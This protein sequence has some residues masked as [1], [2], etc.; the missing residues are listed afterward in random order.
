MTE[1]QLIDFGFERNDETIESSGAPYNWYYYSLD[2]GGLTFLSNSSDEWE[3]EGISVE[4]ME[5]EIRFTT[6]EALY[7]IINVVE[8]NYTPR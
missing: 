5:T 3:S 7:D 4:I 6:S 2:L 1:Q 8:A